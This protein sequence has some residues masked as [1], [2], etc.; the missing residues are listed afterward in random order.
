M[1]APATLDLS[2]AQQA[3]DSQ[4]FSRLLGTRITAFGDGAAT[5]EVG[6]REELHQQNGFLHGGVLSYA[7]DNAITFA[8]GAALGPAVLTGGFSIQYVR[9]ALGHTLVA[10]AE[11][12]HAGRRQAVVRCDLLTVTEDGTEALCAVAQGTVLTAGA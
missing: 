2:S 4:P 3:L 7:A 6:I 10:R 11:V 8:G 1:N 12:V 5:L 9:P